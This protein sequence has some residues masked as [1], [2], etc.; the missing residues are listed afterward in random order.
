M[1]TLDSD[2]EQEHDPLQAKAAA[3]LFE[4]VTVNGGDSTSHATHCLLL[5]SLQGSK[6]GYFKATP[7]M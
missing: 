2:G 6:S 5:P 3:K 4:I 1:L 7:R